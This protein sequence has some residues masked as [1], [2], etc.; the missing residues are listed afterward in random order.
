METEKDVV[1]GCQKLE[2]SL[3]RVSSGE[4]PKWSRLIGEN[5][6]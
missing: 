4:D 1:D 6:I 2:V 5:R 3:R